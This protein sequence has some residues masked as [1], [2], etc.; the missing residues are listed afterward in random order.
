[1]HKN[2][3]QSNS[4]N[5]QNIINWKITTRFDSLVKTNLIIR[6]NLY[7]SSIFEEISL[8]GTNSLAESDVETG[9]LY[10]YK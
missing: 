6:Y 10:V 1:M 5:R 8:P 2:T 4:C 9:L 7:N 3:C